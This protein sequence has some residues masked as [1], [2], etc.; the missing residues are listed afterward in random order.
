MRKMWAVLGSIL[1]FFLAPGVVA[2]LIPWLIS[3]WPDAPLAR[4]VG[5]LQIVGAAL[6]IVGLACLIE[7]FARFAL[8]GL[9]TPAPVAPTKRLVVS[10]LYRHVRNPM[11]DAVVAIILAH[12][13][14]F[15]SWT[16]T[17]YGALV[18]LG[19]T[20]FVAVYE[21]PALRRSFGAEYES[22]CRNVGRWIPRLNAWEP[23]DGTP[24]V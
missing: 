13:L 10:G 2:F 18:W 23:K 3:G 24:T 16:V 1:F 6:G 9:G 7:C 22:Y 11:Y 12:A 8:D 17:G 20:T 14:W 21:E 5:A 19:F 4:E 15:E